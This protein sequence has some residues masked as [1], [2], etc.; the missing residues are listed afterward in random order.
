[1]GRSRHWIFK[2]TKAWFHRQ[3]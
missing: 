1:M 2:N 3:G